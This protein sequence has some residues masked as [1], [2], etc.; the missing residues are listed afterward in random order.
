MGG[1][2]PLVHFVTT[3]QAVAA[4]GCNWVFTDGHG[5]MAFTDFYNELDDL[6]EI[7]WA[8]IHSN[9]WFDTPEQ[10]DRK[11]RKQAEFLIRDSCPWTL[12]S[13]IGVVHSD[14]K[15]QVRGIIGNSQHQPSLRVRRGWYY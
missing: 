5:T 8:I 6:S 4:S 15:R 13:E 7:D 2:E 11:R 12:I 1:Q 9:Y 10:P 3:A 14:M